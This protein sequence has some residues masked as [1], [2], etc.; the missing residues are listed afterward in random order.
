MHCPKRAQVDKALQDRERCFK[1]LFPK[2][3]IPFESPLPLVVSKRKR[4]KTLF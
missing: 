4:T 1:N 3:V 2:I